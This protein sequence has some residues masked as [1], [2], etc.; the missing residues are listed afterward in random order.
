MLQ[1]EEPTAPVCRG[2]ILADDMGLGKTFQ[3]IGLLKNSP[4]TLRTLIICPPALIAGWTA[5]LIACGYAVSVL[6]QSAMWSVPVAVSATPTV[7][8]TSYPKASLYHRFIATETDPFER[9]ILDEGHIIR[10]GQS[11]SRW[12]HCMAIAKRAVCR[13][14]LSATP[15]QNGPSDWKNLC[16][17]LRVTC[18]AAD[19][20]DLG[21]VVMLRR[22]MQELRGVIEA[23]PPPPVFVEHDFTIPAA[24]PEGKLFRVLCDQ[25][26]SV[27]D[28]RSVSALMKLE[29]W[30]RIQQF[31]VHPQIYIE[32]MRAKF[33]RG[34]Y[35]RKDWI[36]G[37]GSG[38][39]SG[40][41]D[42]STKW[43][44]C[45][46]EMEAGV[47]ADRAAGGGASLVFCNFRAEM[48]RVVAAAAAMGA[49]V[50]CIRGGM[51]SEAVGQSV[52][53]AGVAAASG[54][55]VI[56]VQ[57][58]S[59]G[60]GLNLQFCR[61]ILFLSQH[62]NPAVVHQAIGRAVRIG[63]RSVV[64][65]HFFRCVDDVCDNID[66]RMAHVHLAKIEGA[67]AICPTLYEGF[68]PVD[69]F[70]VLPSVLPSP[71]PSPLPV[72]PSGPKVVVSVSAAPAPAPSSPSEDPE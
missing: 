13:W 72:L 46:T 9:V 68:P 36:C 56:V 71:L 64:A 62:W 47:V 52:I 59:G 43:T 61:R 17:W 20:P 25:L 37:S 48:D 30:M 70:P 10:N 51:D 57:I 12:L 66:R 32:A 4:I 49:E 50:F 31:L 24:S 6:M 34:A 7:W 16:W 44:A 8:L 33:G 54:P 65:V 11:T 42:G 40:S 35:G 18:P 38:S 39:G 21:S 3:T 58:V 27:I 5:E 53:D 26:E 69:A 60:A 23:L 63:Q 55:V 41:S 14:I 67:K 45:M 15:V 19:I 1:R 22:T 2:G 28:S 29:L